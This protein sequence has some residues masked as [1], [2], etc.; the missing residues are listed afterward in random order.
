MTLCDW[1]VP[2]SVVGRWCGVHKTTIVRSVLGV[3]MGL[4]P[5]V[6]QWRG[7]R[8]KAHMV[9]VDE[10]WLKIRGRWHSW[11]VVLDV[12]TARPVLA[13]LLPSRSPWAG[14]GVGR[15]LHQLKKVPKVLIT[16]G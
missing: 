2:L 1:N 8:V 5:L 7:E 9:D 6:S 4:W 13:A 11:C 10:K 14:R 12:P 15:Q 16:D 3:A